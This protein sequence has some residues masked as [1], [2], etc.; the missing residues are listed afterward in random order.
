MV[1]NRNVFL[2]RKAIAEAIIKG[3]ENYPQIRGTVRFYQRSDGVVV[4]TRINGLPKGDSVCSSPIFA[5][6]I[7]S[8]SSCTGN[9]ADPFANSNGHYNPN[10]CPH[11]YHAGDLPP[12]FSADGK[13]LSDVLTNRF[14]LSQIIGRAV[15]IHSSFDDFT[16]QPSGNSGQKIACGVI[17]QV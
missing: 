9:A 7:H 13:A 16:T 2:S 8:G 3:S 11:P 17:R 5:M 12:L 14:D 10:N 4:S 1:T 6:H 15:I